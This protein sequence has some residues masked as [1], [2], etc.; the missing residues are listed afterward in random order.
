MKLPEKLINFIKKFKLI[1]IVLFAFFAALP[2][3]FIELEEGNKKASYVA[4]M[5]I[6]M[7]VFWITEIVSLYVTALIP[8]ILLPLFQINKASYVAA[9][10]FNDS[11]FLFFGSFVMG[12]MMRRWQLDKRLSIKTVLVFGGLFFSQK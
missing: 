3:L 11:I 12:L 4:F 2:F 9:S 8:L 6:I 7:S 1:I 5:T 10:Y